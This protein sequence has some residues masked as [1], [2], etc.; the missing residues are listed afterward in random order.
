MHL[1]INDTVGLDI[2]LWVSYCY[3]VLCLILLETEQVTV[4]SFSKLH[5]L[6]AN[7][8]GMLS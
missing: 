8:L 5:R 3:L 7:L 6:V 4:L 1:E 2:T